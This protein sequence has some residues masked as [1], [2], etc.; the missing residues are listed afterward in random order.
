MASPSGECRPAVVPG[1]SRS[2]G[3]AD[4]AMMQRGHRLGR[5]GARQAASSPLSAT[6]PRV[7]PGK[8]PPAVL[9]PHGARDRR[10]ESHAC[11]VAGARARWWTSAARPPP[12]SCP[13]APL[14][15]RDPAAPTRPR[16]GGRSRTIRRTGGSGGARLWPL[17][18]RSYVKCK[19]QRRAVALRG[20]RSALTGERVL[21]ATSRVDTSG[22]A[23]FTIAS[24][25]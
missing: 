24:M 23:V 16:C 10:V 3:Q 4:C 8:G 15:D 9:R 1:A 5:S 25:H 6:S 19:P 17:Q 22:S 12:R 2:T 21:S 14:D 13:P 20:Q 7:V 11:S 18:A